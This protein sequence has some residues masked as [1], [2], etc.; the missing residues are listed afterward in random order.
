MPRDWVEKDLTFCGFIAF[1]CKIRADSP[2]VISALKDSDHAVTMLTGDSPLTS[3]HVAKEVNICVKNKEVAVL[4]TTPAADS[5]A[6]PKTKSDLS[7]LNARWVVHLDDGSDH[8]I[9]FA[10]GSSEQGSISEVIKSYDLVTTEADFVAIADAVSGANFA[11]AISDGTLDIDEALGNVAS[12]DGN[13]V[14]QARSIWNDIGS[15]RVFARMSPQGKRYIL[16]VLQKLGKAA[17]THVLMCGDGGNDVGAL[18]QANVGIA[19]L[20]G[21]ANANT[22]EKLAPK[23]TD[24][25]VVLSGAGAEKKSA[26]D[27]LNAHDADIKA[28]AVAVDKMRLAHMKIWSAN[29]Q[30]IAQAEMQE[31][32]KELTEKG[33]YTAMFS[34]MK[35]QAGKIQKVCML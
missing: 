15:F 35:D 22:T 2:I 31:K 21:H 7:A 10:S 29:Y 9:P 25:S 18:K 16:A 12:S 26:E 1:E 3:I 6:D 4:M 23:E 27:T 5:S 24:S 14:S 13:F 17:G 32:I 34:L 8:I 33:E 20:A 30:K 28:R 19:L 11:K